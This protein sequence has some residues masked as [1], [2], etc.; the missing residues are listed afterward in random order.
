MNGNQEGTA[1]YPLTPT[2]EESDLARDSALSLSSFIKGNDRSVALKVED[3]TISVPKSVFRMLIDI[4]NQMALGNSITI[5]P[6][7]A[8]LTTQEAA[9]YL[10]VSRPY[11]VKLLEGNKIPFRKVGTHRRIL[12]KDLMAYQHRIEQDRLKVLEKLQEDAE[13]LDMGY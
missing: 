7:H 5:T 2:R 13:D 8:E 1:F 3:K 12:F 4:L 9:D 6:I 11:L 10:S